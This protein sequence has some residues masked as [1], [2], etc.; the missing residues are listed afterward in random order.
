MKAKVGL[1]LAIIVFSFQI[2][3]QEKS[4]SSEKFRLITGVRV[5]PLIVYDFEGNANEYMRLHGEFGALFNKKWYVSV[6]YTAV[7]DAIY[8]FNEYWFIGFDKRLPVSWVLAEEYMLKENKLII[9][10]GPNVKLSKIGNVFAFLFSPVSEFNLGLK[11][12]VFI[13][14]NFVI[15]KK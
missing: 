7:A 8:N 4:E 9:Q 12:G 3:A 5:N 2:Y 10:T 15:V 14:L 1:S 13:P 11:V 6:G